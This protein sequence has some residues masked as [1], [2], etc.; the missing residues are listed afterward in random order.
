VGAAPVAG[1]LLGAGAAVIA[2][3]KLRRKRPAASD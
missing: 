2:A 1:G 3:V